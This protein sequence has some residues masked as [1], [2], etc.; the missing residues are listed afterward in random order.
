MKWPQAIGLAIVLWLNSTAVGQ[1]IAER[2]LVLVNDRM[3][4]EIGTG[5]T[6]ASVFVGNYYASK[7]NIP[8]GNVIHL[9]TSTEEAIS[10][11]DYQAEI[12]T[13]LRKILD[14]N[15]GAMRKKILYIVPVYGMP[16]KTGKNGQT[17]AVDSLLSALYMTPPTLIR[18][19]NPYA[20]G[21]GS[22]PPHFDVWADQREASGLWK[23]FLVSRLDGPSAAIA[24]GLVDKAIAAESG[25]ST[26]SGTGYFDYQGTRAPSEPLY[27]S[28]EDMLRAA[29]LSQSRGFT[30]VLNTQREAAC[31]SRIHA[32]SARYYD[33]DT[34]SVNVASYG[35]DTTV[36]RTFPAIEEGDIV[37]G[38]H[39]TVNNT[40]NLVYLTLGT[41]D[42]NTFVRLSYPLAPFTGYQAS[43]QIVLAKSTA[44]KSE[45]ATVPVDKSMQEILDGI[46]EFRFH[47]QNGG[48]AV[49]RN[50]MP[51]ISMTDP[52]PVSVSFSSLSI[53]SHC[54]DFSLTGMQVIK[55]GKAVVSEHFV[56][57]TTANYEWKLSP[58]QGQNALWVWGWYGPAYDAYRFVSGA[59]GA[60]LTSY[61]ANTLR[62][63]VNPDP[64]VRS[65]ADR[66]WAGNWVPRM[67]EEGVTG[68]WGAVEEPYAK[69]YTSGAILFDHFWA[70]YNF[71]ESF[72]L[73]ENV[74]RWTMVSV[75]DPLYAP[76]MFRIGTS[77]SGAQ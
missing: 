66:R 18:F 69:F 5:K 22:R 38:V 60:Q 44:G 55:D 67:L 32:G 19:P 7:R 46:T 10:Y 41:I 34:K 45:K 37:I 13:P 73:A 33:P 52:V 65:F 56:H 16:L 77:A 75:G 1:P 36:T 64:A 50:G 68:T 24:Q 53:E 3:P 47:I 59:I 61:T 26:Q 17:V 58:L 29:K 15:D 8:V 57:N 54:W 49:S 6:S 43:D 20:A 30:T 63:P 11:E 31:G 62:K 27:A 4:S 74:L 76:A 40:G 71:G 23:M 42:A 51:L 25:L 12:E 9:R 2:V 72:Y 21:I 70:G 14:G 35:T 39:G 48:I 28:D